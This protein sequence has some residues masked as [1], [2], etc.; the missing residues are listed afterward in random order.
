MIAPAARR[1]R[2]APRAS[3]LLAAL[4]VVAMASTAGCA[5]RARGDAPADASV[6]TGSDSLRG[7]VRVVG[8]A[9][10]LLVLEGTAVGVVDLTIADDRALR[11]ADGLEVAVVGRAT[12]P[13]GLTPSRSGFAVARFA[14][15][16]VDGIAAVDGVLELDGSEYRLRLADGT[17]ARLA[18]PP[19]ALRAVVG[20]RIYWAGPLE[21]SPRAYG[22]LTRP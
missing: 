20:A 11:G 14:V 6:A 15:R 3:A 17:Q 2:S 9:P 21:A 10:G 8:A 1:D 4:L 16:A 22:I 5:R 13:T 18:S 12:G 19:E 7:T